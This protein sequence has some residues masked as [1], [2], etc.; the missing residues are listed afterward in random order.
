M[1]KYIKKKINFWLNFSRLFFF[2]RTS[3]SSQSNCVVGHKVF[4][5]VSCGQVCSWSSGWNS[6]CTIVKAE[7]ERIRFFFCFLIFWRVSY[8]WLFW[9][10]L[11]EKRNYELGRMRR[12]RSKFFFLEKIKSIFFYKCMESDG[13]DNLTNSGKH[14]VEIY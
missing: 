12:M 6:Y 1:K 2:G 13:T 8:C 10:F 7:C 14:K 4:I 11:K 9:Q 3:S 5:N